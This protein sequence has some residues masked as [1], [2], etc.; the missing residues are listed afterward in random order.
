VMS[1]EPID[2]NQIVMNGSS[3][4]QADVTALAN[5]VTQNPRGVRQACQ[6]L[7]NRMAGGGS[8]RDLAAL[9][10][11]LHLLGNHAE[12][13]ARLKQVEGN[14]AASFILGKALEA[15]ERFE[16]AIEAF[17]DAEKNG[18]DAVAAILCRAGAIRQAGRVSEAQELI[19]QN[20]RTAVTRA[21]YSFQMG[22][23]L[24]DQGDTYGA[25]EYFERAVD[26]DVHHAGALFRLAA[27]NAT[28]GND[29]EAIG[30][31]ERALSRPPYYVGALLNLGLLYED[32]EQYKAA[33]FCF[34]RVLEY[35]PNHERAR[36]Y[37]KDIEAADDM[38]YDEDSMRRDKDREQVLNTSIADFELSARS[39]N[40]LD[41]LG[42]RTLGDLADI[43]EAELMASKNF[44]ETSLKEVRIIMESK[45]LTVG[46][47][48][49][50]V[51][52]A[53]QQVRREDLSEEQRAIYDNPVA[54]LNL[55]V[56][57]RKAVSRLGIATIGE[58]MNR[59]PDELL[60]IR[61]FGVTSLNEIRLRLGDMGVS[62]RND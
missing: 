12:S 36:L 1:A 60:G 50:E 4:G 57:A 6:E 37:L 45:G 8:Q 58:L 18:S 34:R 59:T 28:F 30:L 32:A 22:C 54:D 48:Q 11:G 2:V 41:R 17:A 43:S 46:M 25:I 10:V 5:A 55:S 31:Y 26:M 61:N 23:I 24:A 21:D 35:N 16:E 53:P 7:S 40:C 19:R 27:L 14:G 56:R 52:Q 29:A 13:V 51:R 9:G 62:L 49:A 33:A 38:F 42:I 20:A 44:G 47:N 3:F 39:R 15:L